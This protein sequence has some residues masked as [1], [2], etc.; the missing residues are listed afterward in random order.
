MDQQME[1]LMAERYERLMAAFA[2][3]IEKDVSANT[4][5]TLVFETG[6]NADDLEKLDE[7]AQ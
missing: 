1:E 2:E 5:S 7:C 3:L 6:V 4:I